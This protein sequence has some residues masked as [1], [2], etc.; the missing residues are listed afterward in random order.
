MITL[1]DGRQ[2]LWQWD[3][4][5]EVAVA[6]SIEQVHFANN[7]L[8]KAYV[9]DV[10]GDKA[11]IPPELLQTDKPLKVWG[12]VPTDNGGHT[13]VEKTFEV[14]RRNKP[15]DYVYTPTEQIRLQDAVDTANEAKDIAESLRQDADNG[16]FNGDK[17]EKGDD[18]VLTQEDKEEIARLSLELLPNGDEVSY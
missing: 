17:G 6:E 13:K 1:S 2:G 7:I 9:V 5:V 12:F 18:Y 15:A 10:V 16:V 4:D 11:V 8:G 3:T 14:K